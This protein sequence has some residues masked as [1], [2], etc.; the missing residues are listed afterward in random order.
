MLASIRGLPRLD[1]AVRSGEWRAGGPT[2]DLA[3]ATVG[4]VGLGAIGR[5]VVR[6]LRGF[7]CRVLAVEP[8]PDEE[9]VSEY[10]V[11]LTDLETM[12]PQID[13]LTLH[14]PLSD[15]S[16]HL[17]G[18][19]ELGLLA[20]HAVLV[21]TARGELV[22][23]VALAGALNEHRIAAAGLDVFEREPVPPDDPIL[24]APNTLLSGHISSFTEVGVDGMAGA[25]LSNLREVLAG[26]I[27][28]SCLNP[29][30]WN[31]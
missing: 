8:Y 20:P 2:R 4:V 16:R 22:D 15:G 11:E 14:A 26:K 25:V 24:A 5:A 18:D 9:F 30:A 13:V 10:E 1:A 7:G 6:R 3:R 29:E 12:L 27:P 21:N 28:A 23:Q 31:A 17:I 19:R